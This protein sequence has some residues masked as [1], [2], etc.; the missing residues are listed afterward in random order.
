MA[1]LPKPPITSAWQ[2]TDLLRDFLHSESR[3]GFILIA[4]TLLSLI[5]ANSAL[6][7]SYVHLWHLEIVG[8]YSV[9]YLINDGLMT[10]FFLWLAWRSRGKSIWA[11][12]RTL[13]PPCCL[14]LRL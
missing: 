8:G 2:L 9:E 14:F 13:E 3:A 1:L 4:C 6:S 11:N 7:E 12:C 5:L 10:L